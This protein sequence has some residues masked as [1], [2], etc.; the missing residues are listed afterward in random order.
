MTKIVTGF[1]RAAVSFIG[2]RGAPW[3]SYDAVLAAILSSGI[4]CFEIQQLNRR[5]IARLA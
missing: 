1:W 2:L 3:A 5:L 4:D